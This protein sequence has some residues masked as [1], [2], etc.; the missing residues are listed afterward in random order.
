MTEARTMM[1]RSMMEEHTA[2]ATELLRLQ[3]N[4]RMSL[5]RHG[6]IRGVESHRVA[7]EVLSLVAASPVVRGEYREVW[8]MEMRRSYEKLVAKMEEETL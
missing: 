2:I 1:E 4:I 6:G 5:Q 8:E 3:G 7:S